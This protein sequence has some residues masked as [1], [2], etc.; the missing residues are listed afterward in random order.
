MRRREVYKAAGFAALAGGVVAGDSWRPR[1]A[2]GV[3]GRTRYV[4]TVGSDEHDGRSWATAK[5]TLQ[6]AYDSL[7]EDNNSHGGLVWVDFGDYDIGLGLT[8]ASRQAGDVPWRGSAWVP[9]SRR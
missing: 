7:G 4:S 1:E 8:L 2:A 6:N 5:R 9:P 3:T